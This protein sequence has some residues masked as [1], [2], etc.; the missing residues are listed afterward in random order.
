MSN[1]KSTTEQSQQTPALDDDNN[2]VDFW[3]YDIG[4]N[5]IPADTRNKITNEIW[6]KWQSEPIPEDQHKE[7][8]SNG[9]FNRGI[10]VILGKVFHNKARTGLY[11]EPIR[12]VLLLC[13]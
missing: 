6:L 5:V 4:M 3:R 8:K 12:K 2:W 11:L 9:S 10:A 1:S 7:W 13:K